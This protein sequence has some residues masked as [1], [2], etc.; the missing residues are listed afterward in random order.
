MRQT[1]ECG[2]MG[3]RLTSGLVKLGGKMIARTSARPLAVSDNPVE[4]VSKFK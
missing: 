1:V 2:K 3:N 4:A